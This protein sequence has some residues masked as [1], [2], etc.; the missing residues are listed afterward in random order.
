MN[1]INLGEIIAERQLT[2][3]HDGSAIEVIVRIGKP[4]PNEVADWICPYEI[5][6]QLRGSF[7]Q[8]LWIHCRRSV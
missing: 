8:P 5:R 1:E 7:S 2:G 3:N 4:V 6:F